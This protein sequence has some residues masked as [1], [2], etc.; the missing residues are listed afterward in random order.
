MNLLSVAS[1][2]AKLFQPALA[3]TKMDKTFLE[4][5]LNLEKYG[6]NQVYV[7]YLISLLLDEMNQNF[8]YVNATL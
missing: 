2:G 8:S 1:N 3:E 4:F 5:L 6:L 7:S